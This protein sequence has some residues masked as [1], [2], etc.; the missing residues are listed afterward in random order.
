MDIKRRRV[1]A[2]RT[3]RSLWLLLAAACILLPRLAAAQGL[4]GALIGVVKDE[5]G[6]VLAGASVRIASPALIGGTAMLFTNEKGQLRFP[7]LPPGP[8]SMSIELQGFATLNE[9]ALVIG[10]GAT[11][12]LIPDELPSFEAAALAR[13]AARG[14][15]SI[16]LEGGPT[17]HRAFWDRGLIDRVQM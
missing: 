14:I 3:R 5:Q 1:A 12:E 2:G 10:A 4:T 7:A 17:V 13:L 15:R 6:G 8:Y 16:V 9:A 11:I